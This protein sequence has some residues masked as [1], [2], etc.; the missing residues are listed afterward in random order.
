MKKTIFSCCAGLILLSSMNAQADIQA[1]E[2][3]TLSKVTGQINI[4]SAITTATKLPIRLG[5]WYIK[6]EIKTIKKVVTISGKLIHV[7]MAPAP[8]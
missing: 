2:A 1:L 8:E 7:E 5:K 3:N 4:R 6:S